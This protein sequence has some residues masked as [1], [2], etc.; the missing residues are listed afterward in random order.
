MKKII[1]VLALIGI[2]SPAIAKQI[3]YS[4]GTPISS[5]QEGKPVKVYN[6][7]GSLQYTLKKSNSNEIRQYS[8]TGSYIGKYRERSGKIIYYPKK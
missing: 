8:R 5:V 2:M 1:L 4:D 3:S 6:S 7:H